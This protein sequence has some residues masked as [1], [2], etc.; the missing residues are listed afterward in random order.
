VVVGVEEE[1]GE[2]EEGEIDAS[3]CGKKDDV[4]YYVDVEM[5]RSMARNVEKEKTGW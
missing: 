4:R 5:N 3:N 2:E 1:R